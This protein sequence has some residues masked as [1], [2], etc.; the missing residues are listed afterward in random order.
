[1]P[2][3]QEGL[4]PYLSIAIPVY[5]EEPN[6]YPLFEEITRALHDYSHAYEIIFIDDGSTDRTPRILQ[7]ICRQDNRVKCIIFQGNFGQTAALSAGFDLAKGELIVSLDGDRQNDP[8]DIPRLLN[9]IEQQGYDVVCGWRRQRK[10][11]FWTRRLPSLIANRLIALVTGVFIHDY[12][13]TLK[14]YRK[15]ILKRIRLYGEMHRF[16]PAYVSWAGAKVTE[17]EVN[18]R[19]RVAGNSKYNLFRTFKVML[20]LITVKFLCDYSTSPIYFF[21]TFGI[22]LCGSGLLFAVITLVEKFYQGVW[23]HRNPLILLAIFLFILGVQ[24]IMIGLLAEIL[25]RTYHESQGKKT[26]II[27]EVISVS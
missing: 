9:I 16:I 1:L 15:E 17:V 13:C 24:F 7:D 20:D 3:S 6:I 8:A 4:T 10:D 26:Y 5:N 25:I 22:F 11:S 18:H 14:A 2:A 27:K 12:G 21:G 19:Y 23:V